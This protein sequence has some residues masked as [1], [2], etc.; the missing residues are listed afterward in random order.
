MCIVQTK[1]R[2]GFATI[3]SAHDLQGFLCFKMKKCGLHDRVDW[4][5][6]SPLITVY[7]LHKKRNLPVVVTTSSITV[8]GE[9][10]A[11]YFFAAKKPCEKN[12]IIKNWAGK[13][14]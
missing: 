11:K 7:I 5:Y 4:F 6:Y 10:S 9:L 3:F 12:G 13:E 8:H 14:Y 2:H 1:S